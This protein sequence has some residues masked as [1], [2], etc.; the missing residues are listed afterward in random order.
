MKIDLSG[1]TLADRQAIATWIRKNYESIAVAI[2]GIGIVD[3][4]INPKGLL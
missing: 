4:P 3:L 1:Q 2:E